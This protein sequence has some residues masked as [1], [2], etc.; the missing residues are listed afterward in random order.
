MELVETAHRFARAQRLRTAFRRWLEQGRLFKALRLSQRAQQS[1][2]RNGRSILKDVAAQNT[3]PPARRTV[4]STDAAE[5]IPLAASGATSPSAPFGSES[6]VAASEFVAIVPE[7]SVHFAT[8]PPDPAHAPFQI[9]VM[10]GSQGTRAC[11]VRGDM[12]IG[13]L[14]R[15]AV[16]AVFPGASVDDCF[17]IFDGKLVPSY[18]CRTLAAYGI[19]SRSILH[20]FVKGPS[21]QR[22]R[23]RE[24]GGS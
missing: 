11:T 23:G 10:G 3:I 19:T 24:K 16:A 7:P 2:R 8:P 17:I 22:Q 6:R 5:V 21:Q 18:E 4:A 15:I 14:R 12:L 20:V 1:P 9:E 13:H